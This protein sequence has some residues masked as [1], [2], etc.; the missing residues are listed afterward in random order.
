MRTPMIRRL[1]LPVLALLA[2]AGASHA[3]TYKGFAAP[4]FITVGVN[5]SHA[6]PI[7][8]NGDGRLDLLVANM[9]RFDSPNTMPFPP[10]VQVLVWDSAAGRFVVDPLQVWTEGNANITQPLQIVKA[11]LNGDGRLDAVFADGPSRTVKSLVFDPLTGRFFPPIA[12]QI[13]PP[14]PVDPMEADPF[15]PGNVRSLDLGDLNGDGVLTWSPSSSPTRHLSP[16]SGGP[17]ATAPAASQTTPS[18]TPAGPSP[19]PSA[20]S[21]TTGSMTWSSATAGPSPPSSIRTPTSP[22]CST[23]A[24]STPPPVRS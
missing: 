1:T 12:S 20:T 4:D 10:S 24:P 17:S 23:P 19:W 21:T 2:S 3:Q 22:S 14:P 16:K 15:A 6:M 7:D 9:G 8:A 5:P 11:D 13:V 18:S